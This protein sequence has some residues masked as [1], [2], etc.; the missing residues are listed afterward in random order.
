MQ[1]SIV[2]T[3]YNSA[4]YVSKFYE[5]TCSVAE[6]ITR[7]F[8]VVFVNDGS[9]DASLQEAL[10]LFDQDV[11]VRI[12]DL[13]R[14]FGHHQAMMAGL[15]QS[16]GSLVFLIDVDLEEPPEILMEFYERLMMDDNYDVVFGVQGSRKGGTI[17]RIGGDIFYWI[18]NM[19]SS[20][21]I[22]KNQVTARLMRRNY[23]LSLLQHN[24]K[25]L[26]IAGLWAL[27]GFKQFPITVN[28]E[29]RGTTSYSL[30]RRI[31]IFVNA[32]V[33]FTNKPLI[34]IFYLGTLIMAVSGGAGL[35]LVLRW[36]FYQ[37][38][39]AGWP[40]L[41]VSVWFLG[42][43]NIFCLGIIGFYIAKI[44]SETKNRPIAIVRR[45]YERSST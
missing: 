9:P 36:M 11:R 35:Y 3:L 10:K 18:F 7:D 39:L 33:S 4:P 40:S 30:S 41:I 12:I 31:A 28:K 5:R 45:I 37:E 1:L 19:F 16:R 26:C 27:T 34:Y 22:P 32:L 14:N 29:S 23:V 25:E 38:F 44:F 24:E 2:T 8:E 20:V 42:G 21:P 6:Q 43:T 15:M 13:S 17:E